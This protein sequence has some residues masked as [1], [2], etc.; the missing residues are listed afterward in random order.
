VEGQALRDSADD[1]RLADCRVIGVSFDTPA[2]NKAFADAQEFGYP[3]LSDVDQTVGRA[4]DVVRRADDQY[5]A[6]PMRVSYLIDPGGV[7]RRSYVVAD[8][9][10]HAQQVLEDLRA[11]A[12]GP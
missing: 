4:Y 6:F 12:T 7:I 11:L 9:A 10:G 5:A 1:F 2:D 3:L 8:V